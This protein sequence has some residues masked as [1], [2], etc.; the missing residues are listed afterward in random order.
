[1]GTSFVVNKIQRTT[2]YLRA[3]QHISKKTIFVDDL[4]TYGASYGN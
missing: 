4:F 1:M 2:Y 3:L